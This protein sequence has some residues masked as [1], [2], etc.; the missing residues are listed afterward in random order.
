LLQANRNNLAGFSIIPVYFS[1][2][3]GSAEG[4]RKAFENMRGKLL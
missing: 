3:K 4:R 2:E 1:G